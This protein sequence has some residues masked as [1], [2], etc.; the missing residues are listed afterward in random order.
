VRQLAVVLL[1]GGECTTRFTLDERGVSLGREPTGAVTLPMLDTE[2]SRQHSRIELDADGAWWAVDCGSR[3]GTLVDGARVAARAPLHD[4]S[5]VRIG[6]SLFVFTDVSLPSSTRLLPDSGPLRGGSVAMQR[7]RGEIALVAPSAAPV[8]ILGESGTGKELAAAEIHRASGRKGAFVAINCAAIP[9][10]LAEAELFGHA[11]GAFTGATERTEGLFAAADGGTLLL[12]EVGELDPTIQAKLLRA[13]ATGET[14]PLGRAESRR[15]NVRML[16]AT[17][18][19]LPALVG[20][21]SFRGDL[22]A[23]LEA[24]Q[25]RLPPLRERRE[26]VLTI[27]RAFLAKEGQ[28]SALG[29]SAAEALTLFDWPFNVRQLENVLRAAALRAGKG[30]MLLAHLPE[31]IQARVGA[32]S[33]SLAPPAQLPLE[34]AVPRDATPDAAQLEAVARHFDGNVSQMAEYF[35][36]DRKQIYRWAERLGIDRALWRT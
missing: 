15:I 31:E 8:L 12:D 27:A 2:I 25:V 24:H 18:R 32:R 23:R 5:V 22:H 10:A 14:R 35:A 9:A 1:A 17:H 19:D 33:A 30:E 13:L 34:I 26:D 20:A 3:N 7:V 4:G 11:A 29:V 28:E 16:A 21:G 36:K 6:R